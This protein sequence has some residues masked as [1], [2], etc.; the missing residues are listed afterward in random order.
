MALSEAIKS[1]TTLKLLNLSR[2]KIGEAGAAAL[3]AAPNATLTELIMDTKSEDTNNL[4]ADRRRGHMLVLE[5]VDSWVASAVQRRVELWLDTSVVPPARLV[6]PPD[7][8]A[9]AA[10]LAFGDELL[11]RALPDAP[12]WRHPDGR[13]SAATYLLPRAEAAL[14]RDCSGWLLAQSASHSQ[15]LIIRG[16]SY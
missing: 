16:D 7:L 3:L 12:E 5:V 1:N 2:N 4:R 9:S 14:H 13:S 15:S 11:D 6:L 8:A 10:V